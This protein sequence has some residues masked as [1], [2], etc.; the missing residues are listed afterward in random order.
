MAENNEMTSGNVDALLNN[1]TP[2][3]QEKKD[4]I[5]NL[6]PIGE[7]LKSRADKTKELLED[8]K[9]IPSKDQNSDV[10]KTIKT[11]E[12]LN[13]AAF[14]LYAAFKQMIDA[15]NK[16]APEL[17]THEKLQEYLNNEIVPILTAI[18][19]QNGENDSSND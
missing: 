10:L 4:L 18:Q 11:A 8:L 16:K 6:A 9:A 1:I 14:S 15:Y 12:E 7:A 3:E 2:L 17:N 19:G 5:N 13:D